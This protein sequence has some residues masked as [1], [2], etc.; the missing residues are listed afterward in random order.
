MAAV[1]SGSSELEKEMA[2]TNSDVPQSERQ[3]VFT[4]LS[5]PNFDERLKIPDGLT[6]KLN[7][8]AAVGGNSTPT[9]LKFFPLKDKTQS[10]I[11]LPIDLAKKAAQTYNAM[12][13]GYFVGPRLPFAI[14]Q[15]YVKA[16]WGKF[17]FV[18]MMMNPNG[19]YFFKFN[20]KG[21]CDQVIEA[22]PLMIRGVPL[23]VSTWDPT[24][25]LVKPEHT[26]CPLWVKLH[27][28]PLVAFNMEGISRIAI[29]LGVPKQVDA[30]TA[31][32]CDNAWGRPGFAKVLVDIWA[33]GELKRELEVVIPSITGGKEVPVTIR[34]EYLWEPVQCTHCLVFG[35]KLSTC[36]KLNR[37]PKPKPKQ[38]QKDDDGFIT[39]G[40]K[41]W[42]PKQVPSVK[43]VEVVQPSNTNDSTALNCGRGYTADVQEDNLPSKETIGPLTGTEVHGDPKPAGTIA[44]T[45]PGPKPLK[46]ILKNTNRFSVLTDKR[47][48]FPN[49]NGDEWDVG[50]RMQS[51][52]RV[53]P[54]RLDQE[55]NK[56]AKHTSKSVNVATW[57]IRGL[58]SPEKQREIEMLL[59]INEV[60]L[61]CVLE[62]RIN[63]DTLGTIS[64]R[65]FGRW[66]WMSN[67]NFSPHGT[68]I[69]VAWDTNVM[70]V[71][72]LESHAQF[73][74]CEIRIR[75]MSNP[76]FYSFVYGANYGVERRQLRSGLRKFRAIIG[77]QPWVVSGDFN[78]MLFPHD[79]LGGVSR[80]NADMIEFFECVEDVEL[81]DVRYLG[82]QH[83]WCQR[84]KEESGL[85]HKLDR[86][87][88]NVQFTSTFENTTVQFLPR[89]LSDHSPSL[90]CFKG[91]VVRKKTGF[92][93]DNFIVEN[94]NFLPTVKDI[95]A[96]Q[97][98][99]TFMF[100]V[101]SKLKALKAPLKRIRSSLGNLPKR[102]TLLKSELDTVQLACDLDPFNIELKEDLEALR[103]AY[104]QALWDENSAAKQRAKVHWLK[105]GDSNTRFF[106]NVV[107]EKR[108]AQQ[109][110]AVIDTSGT[111]VYDESVPVAFLEHL[112]SFIGTKDDSLDPYMPMDGFLNK[113]AAVDA[114]H[115]IRPIL[116]SEIRKAM[117]SIGNDKAPGSDGFT[118]KFFKASW[119]IVG[120][121]VSVAIHN[122][123][124]RGHL[125]KE[126][127]HTLIC[128]LPK[129]PNASTVADYRPIACCSVL[130]KCISKILVERMKPYLGSLV[131]RAES[132]FIP[133]R[134]IID[135]ILM[136][137]ELVVGYHLNMGPPRCAFKIDLRKAYDMVDW[138]FL[139]NILIG[140]GFHP[141]LIGWI[142]EMISTP[143]YSVVVNG[144]S[145]GFFYG[146]RGIRQGDPLSPY[147]FT[148]VMEGFSMLFRQCISKATDFG[149][150]PGCSD[151]DLTH[152]CFANDLFVFTTGDVPS[153][154]ILKKALA[155]FQQ[156]SG[157]APNL[158]KSDVFFGNV[159]NG[160]K[161]AILQCLSFRMGSF[162]IRYLGVPL[163]P[164]FLKVADYGTLIAKAKARI[165]NWKSKFLSFGGRKQLIISVMQSLQLFWM[166]VFVLPS[167]VIHELEAL[168]RS[169]LWTQ[170]EPMAGR[171]KLAWDKLCRP[172][173]CGG[174]GFKRLSVWNRALVA[175]NLWDIVTRR[176][177]LWVDRIRMV[178]IRSNNFWTVRTHNSW[179]WIL[180]KM[181]VIRDQ[182]RPFV[183]T[184]IG[185]GMDTHAWEDTWIDGGALATSISYRAIHS[186]GFT[187]DTTVR[188]LL[189]SITTWP[190]GWI[191]RSPVL[192]SIPLPSLNDLQLDVCKWRS[193]TH[194]LVDFTVKEA[195]QSLDISHSH[196]AWTARVWFS[197]HIPKHAFCLWVARHERL[198][199]HD[200][201]SM[202]KHDPPDWRCSLCGICMDSHSHFFFDCSYSKE[203]WTIVVT[204]VGWNHAPTSW[205][206]IMSVIND[207]RLA[208][209]KFIHKVSLAAT[210]YHVWKER[211]RRI[212]TSARIAPQILAKEVLNVIRMRCAWKS[213]VKMRMVT[214][215][216]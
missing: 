133:G 87:L 13:F 75:G 197:G 84:P 136:A 162:P 25:G 141:V 37:V 72:L 48:D 54:V 150:H 18:D 11:E 213:M 144:V 65:V 98:D 23:F 69:L 115:M 36:T 192:A 140:C 201:L 102:V 8:A 152:L 175:K 30:C 99:G 142:K 209:K 183:H 14:I 55:L 167:A 94:P 20:T 50:N 80:R 91:G 125:A 24:L 114:L 70:D 78:A 199:T 200:R 179:S 97:V 6:S 12:L 111:Y 104:Q 47:V 178:Y 176:P 85:R 121:D 154:E 49:V 45:A 106:H 177:T 173:N 184:I 147:L 89:G 139:L 202:W 189:S 146:K 198:P 188:Q 205:D 82:I 21:G 151:I 56:G 57:N 129:S 26:T 59:R 27:N 190:E 53:D 60:N 207:D 118:S 195:Y 210:V 165:H 71:M 22:G 187:R 128:L 119:D 34:V 131:N 7:F 170:G 143:S 93:F 86:V 42:R 116:D 130:Y 134:R 110:N 204:D 107:K 76:L 40:R 66:N 52:S 43:E 158:A 33:I 163:S 126:L 174:L 3:S 159:S 35:H 100:Q 182:I 77:N 137:H 180:R 194:G 1:D 172:K 208:P 61:F 9:S 124:Y 211:N 203:V 5:K 88:A 138:D 168:M 132:A 17:G 109:I 58:N 166:A 193:R 157:L 120:N 161:E 164:L 156:K 73:L 15:N 81:F 67:Q 153:V 28:I 169:F 171:C 4:R 108:N 10:R 2:G 29:A 148:L 46:S 191:S 39:V 83:T 92:K 105:D 215:V 79:A 96:M 117:F 127:N 122:F 95:W 145:K 206:T 196:V 113:V 62:T 51:Q 101:T 135:N 181:M 212:F 63:G 90:L 16:A 41:E 185:N 149:Y 64:R 155:L 160:D 186:H 19:F 32:M 68:R 123:F 103:G 214:N 38:Q 74:N 112:K 31:S 44:P 216:D